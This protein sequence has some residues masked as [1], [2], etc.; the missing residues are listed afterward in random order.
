[1]GLIE[2]IKNLAANVIAH[3][4]TRLDLF[5]TEFAEEK[6]RVTLLLLW[7]SLAIFFSFMVFVLVTMFVLSVYW[8][9]PYRLHAIG[10]LALFFIAG[11]VIA[12]GVVRINLKSNQRLFAASLAELYKDR[13][14]LNSP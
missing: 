7:A 1:M 11:A 5:S 9:T 6:I 14:Q 4:H 8:D 3:V 12:G 10:L 13:E 2:S